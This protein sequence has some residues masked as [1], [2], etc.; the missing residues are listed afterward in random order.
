MKLGGEAV[1][2][3]SYGCVF[4]PSLKCSNKENRTSGVSKLMINRKA[5]DEFEEI[6]KFVPIIKKIENNNDYFLIPKGMCNV[7]ALTD[8]DKVNFNTKCENAF[9]GEYHERNINSNLNKFKVINLPDGG[10]DFDMWSNQ[11]HKIK[12]I[13]DINNG[14]VR[15]LKRGIIPMNKLHLYHTD[16]K[17]TNVLVGSDNKIRIIDWG[18]SGISENVEHIPSFLSFRPLQY[19]LPFSCMLFNHGT[20]REIQNLC[21]KYNTLTKVIILDFIKKHY[22]SHIKQNVGEGH[23]GYLKHIFSGILSKSGSK[24]FSEILF[25]YLTDIIYHFGQGGKFNIKEYYKVF[26]QN[27]DVWGFI[28]IY[29]ALLHIKDN[30]LYKFSNLLKNIIL[31]HLL[32]DPY[33]PINVSELSRD[34]KSLNE[35]LNQKQ[36]NKEKLFSISGLPTTPESSFKNKSTVTISFDKISNKKIVPEKKSAD[37][38]DL[39]NDKKIVTLK[40]KSSSVTKKKRAK[41]CANGTRRNKKTGNCETYNKKEKCK[42]TYK[43]NT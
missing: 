29:I 25:N 30:S 32:K 42:K 15:L 17:D 9:R 28:T 24:P 5:K 6:V 34:L 2:S 11:P 13:I 36:L 33:K 4:R 35:H 16:I 23:Y 38:D 37:T 10:N 27:A 43:W 18:L 19:N 22:N 8:D 21:E 3:G 12:D 39:G 20:M 26:L 31:K 1:G 41:R 14:L 7:G 40:K